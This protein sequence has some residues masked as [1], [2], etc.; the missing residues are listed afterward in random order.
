MAFDL[1]VWKWK[2]ETEAKKVEEIVSAL[3]E[4]T[5]HPSLDHFDMSALENSIQNEF[6]DVNNDPDGPFLYEVFDYK[7]A[8]A[9]WMTISI[10]WSQVE[11][12]LRT[13]IDIAKRQKLCVFD[14][15][16]GQSY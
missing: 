3:A 13:I 2:T 14:P 15:Q 12:S 5:P 4:E 7:D 6:G 11:H 1:Y 9:N 10:N 16:T 8:A